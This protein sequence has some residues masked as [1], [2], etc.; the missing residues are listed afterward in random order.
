MQPHDNGRSEVCI[1]FVKRT[2]KKCSDTNTDVKSSSPAGKTHA[3]RTQ[4]AMCSNLTIQQ[5]NKRHVAKN[6]QVTD[7][8]QL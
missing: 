5:T 1:K 6:Q 4:N 2:M 3:Y 7:D 8:M